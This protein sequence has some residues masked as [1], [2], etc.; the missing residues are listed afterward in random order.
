MEAHLKKA[1]KFEVVK[2]TGSG[3]GGCISQGRTYQV[4]GGKKIYVKQNAG[5][6]AKDMFR[7]EYESLL[8]LE[9]TGCIRV[10]HPI[11]VLDAP[12]G[13]AG[14]ILV[15]E[16]LDLKSVSGKDRQLGESVAR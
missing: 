3:G 16:H 9:K 15:M 12:P 7:G 8:A 2:D 6:N 11:A 4:D 10:P 13:H 1:L 5:G 14:A